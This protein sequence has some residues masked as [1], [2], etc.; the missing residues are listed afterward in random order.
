MSS[1]PNIIRNQFYRPFDA[2]RVIDLFQRRDFTV[3]KH[4]QSFNT[5]DQLE[6]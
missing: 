3:K 5:K 6:Q 1:S 4:R 2:P